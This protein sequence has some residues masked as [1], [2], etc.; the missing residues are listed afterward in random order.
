M[1]SQDQVTRHHELGYW[2]WMDGSLKPMVTYKDGKAESVTVTPS[3]F[4]EYGWTAPEAYGRRSGWTYL[5]SFKTALETRP[6]VI[7][8]HQW[9]EYKGQNIGKGHGP[10][11]DVFLDTYSVEFSDDLEPISP[12]APGYRGTDPYGFYYMNLT[13]ALMDIYRGDAKDVTLMAVN[14]ADSTGNELKFEWTTIGVAPKSFTVKLDGKTLLENT[15]VL[16]CSIP[17][18]EVKPGDHTLSVEAN[19]AGTRY[20]LSKFQYDGVS[21]KLMPLIVDKNFRISK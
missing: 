20:E 19:G 14:L 1:S 15:N 5:E 10:N 3:F 9:N 6:R 7:M 13:R 8:L 4:A 17:R 16:T 2:S 18:K 21:A 12:T 11:K